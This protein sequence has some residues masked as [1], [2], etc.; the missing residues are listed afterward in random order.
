MFLTSTLYA[1]NIT[2]DNMDTKEVKI[3]TKRL[4]LRKWR[5]EDA[6]YMFKYASSPDVGPKAGW[7]PHKDIEESKSII[8]RFIDHNPYC[9]AICLKED[10]SHPIGAVELKVET[11][12]SDRNDEY[13][14]GYWLG[15]PYWGNGYM[16]EAGR[17]LIDFGFKELKLNAIWCGYYDGNNNS[18]RAQEKMGFVYHHTE[19][20]LYVKH[21]D[22]YRKG[23]VSLLTREAWEQ[24][25]KK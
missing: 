18:K 12:M 22:E 21:F 24:I 13:E 23:Y 11:D 1:I 6:P 3:K 10:I 2:I 16:P 8:E 15:K 25:N 17:A 20:N 14:L 7:K 9:F 4:I 19:E 5:L